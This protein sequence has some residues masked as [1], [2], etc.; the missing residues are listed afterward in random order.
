MHLTLLG[1][2]TGKSTWLRAGTREEDEENPM[3][4]SLYIGSGT[5]QEPRISRVGERERE[6]EREDQRIP[7]THA[8]PSGQ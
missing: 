4:D 2:A 6:R 1:P 8:A 3:T 7:R 5:A